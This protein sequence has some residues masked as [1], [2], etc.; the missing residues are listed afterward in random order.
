MGDQSASHGEEGFV[1]QQ[2]PEISV[3][4]NKSAALYWQCLTICHKSLRAQK[5]S[6]LGTF[7]CDA[8][9]CGIERDLWSKKLID[10]SDNKETL[11]L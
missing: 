1:I 3:R 5:M 2:L 6:S 4:H 10:S 11:P 8:E 7:Y 9:L